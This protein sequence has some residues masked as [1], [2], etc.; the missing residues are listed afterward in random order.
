MCINWQQ[1]MTKQVSRTVC[2]LTILWATI[3]GCGGE[4]RAADVDV[5]MART[6]LTKVLDHWRSGGALE[7]F[8]KQIPE[9][10]IQESLWSEGRVLTGYAVLGEPRAENANWFCDVELT[11]AGENG[12]DAQKK[13][14]TY[15]VGTDPVLTVFRAMI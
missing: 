4:Q 15:A 6:T 14:V 2:A 7:D 3:V 12:G 1:A 9:I 10:V 11:L 13:T 5:D 8:R